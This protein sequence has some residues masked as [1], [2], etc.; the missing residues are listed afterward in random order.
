MVEDRGGANISA[1]SLAKVV[2]HRWAE[3]ALAPNWPPQFA[4]AKTG[5]LITPARG[6]RGQTRFLTGLVKAGRAE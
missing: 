4:T 3:R 1:V 6:Q 2:P 5:L